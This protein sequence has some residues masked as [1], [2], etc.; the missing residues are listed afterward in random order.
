MV[1]VSLMALSVV[2]LRAAETTTRQFEAASLLVLEYKSSLQARAGLEVGLELLMQDQGQGVPLPDQAWRG[3][4]QNRGLEVRIKPCAAKLNLHALNKTQQKRQPWEEAVLEIFR[5]QELSR[6]ELE[7]LLHWMGAPDVESYHAESPGLQDSYALKGL[8][9]SAPERELTRPEE[10]LLI[11]GFKD[12]SAPWLRQHFTL[13]GRQDKI[14]INFVARETALALLPELKPYWDR[15]EDFRQQE[16]ISHPN[17]L[18]T[19]INMDLAVYNQ[20]LPFISWDASYY[21]ILVRVQ[22]GQWL[23]EH[24]FIVRLNRMNP[25]LPPEVLVQDILDTRK[26]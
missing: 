12:V 2:V 9:Y 3:T 21:E 20:V 22:E 1:L 10:L 5:D 26:I 15:I 24:R 11:P 16:G 25:E 4:W 23:E 8:H 13:W 18:L 19:E 17:Q 7:N 6:F 14:N